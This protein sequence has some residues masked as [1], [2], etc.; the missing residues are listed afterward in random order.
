MPI[1]AVPST[2]ITIGLCR[3]ISYEEYTG[4]L[5]SERNES[6]TLSPLAQRNA[7]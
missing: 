4:L 3:F 5:C 7:G 1:R 6:L 2:V